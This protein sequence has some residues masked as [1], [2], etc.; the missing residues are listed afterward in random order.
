MFSVIP[1]WSGC[2]SYTTENKYMKTINGIPNIGQ[3]LPERQTGVF[4]GCHIKWAVEA[5][6]RLCDDGLNVPISRIEPVFEHAS[7]RVH[8]NNITKQFAK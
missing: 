8:P 4:E 5:F 7:C 1:F 3:V 6:A 2:R